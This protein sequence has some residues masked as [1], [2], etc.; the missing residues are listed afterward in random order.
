VRGPLDKLTLLVDAERDTSMTK[1]SDLSG[2]RQRPPLPPALA[3]QPNWATSVLIKIG[4]LP[5]ERR[6]RAVTQK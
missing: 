5:P 4:Q 6:P 2:N 1:S 3:S